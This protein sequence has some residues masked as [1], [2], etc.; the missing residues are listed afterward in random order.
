MPRVTNAELYEH[1]KRIKLLHKSNLKIEQWNVDEVKYSDHYLSAK[2][3]KTGDVKELQ[4]I[5]ESDRQFDIAKVTVVLKCGIMSTGEKYL[6]LGSRFLLSRDSAEKELIRLTEEKENEEHLL[7]N[8]HT[9]CGY[10][11]KIVPDSQIVTHKIF[12]RGRKE[13][14]NS[15]KNRYES[16]AYITETYMK[17]CSGTCAGNEQMSRE[18]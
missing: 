3:P 8:G 2:K 14:W 7:A 6:D 11:R 4:S 12:G 17:F 1:Y 9:A 13:V 18:G 16:K 5:V 15:W 10:C